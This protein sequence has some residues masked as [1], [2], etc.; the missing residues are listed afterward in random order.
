MLASA[1]ASV[2]VITPE[3]RTE[4]KTLTQW[5]FALAFVSVGLEFS[6]TNLRTAGW[7]PIAVY[8]GATVFNTVLAL[9]IA[10]LI[11]G[12]IAGA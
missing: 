6:M 9:V 1:L 4:L 8:G 7:R 11:F 12:G 2:G 5:A 10:S 3:L